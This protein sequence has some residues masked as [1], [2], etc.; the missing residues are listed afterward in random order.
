[1]IKT[2]ILGEDDPF[3]LVPGE[4]IELAAKGFAH[5]RIRDPVARELIL[6]A[7]RAVGVS[8]GGTL[9]IDSQTLLDPDILVHPDRDAAPSAEGYKVVPGPAVLLALEVSASSLAYDRRRKAAL[10]SS[11]G[12]AE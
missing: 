4:L 3:E 2:G 1:M 11:Y 10:Y 9:Q 5:D 6:G 7:G 8:V 12:I